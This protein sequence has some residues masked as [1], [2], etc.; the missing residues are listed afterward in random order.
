M[1]TQPAVGNNRK[2][3]SPARRRERYLA[4]REQERAVMQAYRKANPEKVAELKKRWAGLNKER[5]RELQAERRRA[6]PEARR[7]YE[8]DRIAKNPERET[9][10]RRAYY[11]ANKDRILKRSRAWHANN[12]ER[13]SV[14]SKARRI[15][16]WLERA[17]WTADDLER[18]IQAGCAICGDKKPLGK[19]GLV[20][21]HDHHTGK[22]RGLLCCRCNRFL[23]WVL[24]RRDAVDRYIKVAVCE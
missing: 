17:G 16:L 9:E 7:Q 1:E 8:R 14:T 6:D 12:K 21:D 24:E 2:G 15:A 5:V 3:Y 10:R 22:V 11:S 18:R 23:D 19:S 13:K 20:F 4:N